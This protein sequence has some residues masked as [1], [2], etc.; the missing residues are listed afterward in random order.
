M[1]IIFTPHQNPNSSYLL[2]PV[3][4]VRNLPEWYKKLRPTQDN[5]KLA[6]FPN[7]TTNSTVKW[8][9][10]FGDALQAGYHLLLSHDVFVTGDAGSKE[11]VWH[12]GGDSIISTHSKKQISKDLIP[13]GFDEQ[14][15]KFEN[16]FEINT[17]KG[18]SCLIIHPLNRGDLPF[19]TLAGIVETDSYD[20]PVNLPFLIKENFTGIIP[21]GTPIAQIIPLKRDSWKMGFGEFDADRANRNLEKLRSKLSRS[22]KKMFWQRKEWM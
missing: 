7:G 1:K 11:F 6:H 10:P 18:Y 8:C 13:E 16:I 4:A 22:Y 3:P 15:F 5:E 19:L 14:P 21:S 12:A 20:L 17:P 9:N 2:E